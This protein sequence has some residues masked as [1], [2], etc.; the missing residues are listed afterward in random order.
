MSFFCSLVAASNDMA[1]N[2]RL[3]HR[4]DSR[5]DASAACS[6]SLSSAAATCLSAV[7]LALMRE[8][9]CATESSS[10]SSLMAIFLTSGDLQAGQERGR[11]VGSV[12]VW[13]GSKPVGMVAKSIIMVEL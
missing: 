10:C 1:C 9:A 11:A 8:A 2:N 6:S 3:A 7:I 13:Q 12:P 5:L 4:A